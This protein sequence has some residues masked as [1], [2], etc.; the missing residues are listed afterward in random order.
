[1]AVDGL[2]GHICIASTQKV[3]Q[4]MKKC[5]ETPIYLFAFRSL[6]DFEATAVHVAVLS[7][8]V[9]EITGNRDTGT[10]IP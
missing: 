7:S 2:F 1:M 5:Q 10:P 6:H 9:T 3:T 4:V 8:T